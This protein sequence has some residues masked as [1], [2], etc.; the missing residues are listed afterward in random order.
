MDPTQLEIERRQRELET[1]R[2]IPSVSAAGPFDRA[3]RE[4]ADQ[5][6]ALQELVKPVITVEAAA[7]V[8]VP[9]AEVRMD[10]PDQSAAISALTSMFGQ[11][12]EA[13]AAKEA[14]VNVTVDAV[15]VN[16]TVIDHDEPKTVTFERNS[17]N[18]ITKAT[19]TGG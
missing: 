17:L 16:V 5:A 10:V 11:L 2:A 12:I 7:P 4:L 14:V 18:L 19:V 15:P 8:V 3:I 1:L 6:R 9:A 13:L